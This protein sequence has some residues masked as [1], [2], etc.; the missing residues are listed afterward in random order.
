MSA[1]LI[2][3]LP[4]RTE[5]PEV[6]DEGTPRPEYPQPQFEREDWRNLNGIWDFEFDDWNTGLQENWAS[7]E[8]QF[9]QSI[10][11]PFCFESA[12]SGIGDPGEHPIVWY[13]R[14]FE[15]PE[16]WNKRRI[17]L[18]FGAVDYRATVW[19]NGNLVGEHE[20]GHTPFRFDVGWCVKPGQNTVAVRVEDPPADRYIPRGKQ[21]WQAKPENIFYTRTTGIWQTVWLEPV[22]ESYI[23]RVR[24]DSKKWPKCARVASGPSSLKCWTGAA[25]RR[26]TSV[27]MIFGS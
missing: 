16:H 23:E 17:L 9:S 3:Q 24:I 18:H 22:G 8:R 26:S 7:A 10:V 4:L 19:V 20:G 21:H 11:V 1:V 27:A 25:G 2:R 12:A 6:A 13:R 5:V 15:I 14:Q